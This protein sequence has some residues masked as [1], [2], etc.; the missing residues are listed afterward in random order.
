LSALQADGIIGMSPVPSK[1]S[2]M[3]QAFKANVITKKI[4]SI[5]LDKGHQR[6]SHM[7]INGYDA[8][9]YAKSD[10]VWHTICPK[11]KFWSIPFAAFNLGGVNLYSRGE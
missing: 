7:T 2:F 3:T 11:I 9:R 6:N 8:K 1:S 10:V 5:A 4:F